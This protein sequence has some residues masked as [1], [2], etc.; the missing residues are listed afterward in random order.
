MK[1]L[2]KYFISGVLFLVPS[3]ISIWVLFKIFI[4]MDGIIGNLVKKYL[5]D[6]YIKGLG[7][8]SLILLIL[9]LGFLAHNFFGKKFLHSIE[10]IF[11]T[12]PFLN[13]IYTFVNGI[14]QTLLKKEKRVFREVIKIELFSNTFTI[15]F[16][17]GEQNIN[18]EK[19]VSVFVPTVPNISTGFYVVLPEKKVE[20]L[21]ISVEDAFKIVVSMGIFK[22]EK[23]EQ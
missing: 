18:G 10:R 8:I 9:I 3:F 11:E 1:N 19:Y 22:P 15:G 13:K 12:L 4:F 23:W 21:D 20:K 17:T 2:K 5:P 7:F 14:I 16:V 6:F